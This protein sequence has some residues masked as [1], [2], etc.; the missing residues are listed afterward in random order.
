MAVGDLIIDN[1]EILLEA[2]W[3]VSR[4]V[5]KKGETKKLPAGISFLVSTFLLLPPI[6]L[7]LGIPIAKVPASFIG[8]VLPFYFLPGIMQ[9][10]LEQSQPD[11]QLAIKSTHQAVLVSLLLSIGFLFLRV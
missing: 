6:L 9:S 3:R 7:L 1:K 8:L 4:E 11:R 2:G 5:E 10:F